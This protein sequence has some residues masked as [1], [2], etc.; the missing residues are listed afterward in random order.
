MSAHMY[1]FKLPGILRLQ[2]WQGLILIC[3]PAF[4]C[5]TA[6]HAELTQELTC[7]AALELSGHDLSAYAHIHVWHAS[8]VRAAWP[9]LVKDLHE[10][11][12]L[13]W[14]AV[15]EHH[16]RYRGSGLPDM[17]NLV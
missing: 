8:C 15:T 2:K 16:H 1:M 7:I 13:F 10:H 14:V 11:N 9:P 6:A 5:Y 17:V 4:T 12:M 3:K